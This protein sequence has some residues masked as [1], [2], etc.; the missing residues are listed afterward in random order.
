MELSME[1]RLV[2]CVLRN[3]NQ[4]VA[5][6]SAISHLTDLDVPE[7]KVLLQQLMAMGL[8]SR[9]FIQGVARYCAVP[10]SETPILS[11]PLDWLADY[12]SRPLKVEE[13][14]SEAVTYDMCGIVLLVAVLTGSRES[15]V[16]ER[17]T[18][19]PRNFV[20][21]VIALCDRVALWWSQ[22]LFDLQRTIQDD[23]DDF[24]E[25]DRAVECVKEHFWMSWVTPTLMAVL[26]SSREYMQCGGTRDAW[27]D[28]PDQDQ[29]GYAPRRIEWVN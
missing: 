11:N 20:G 26:H 29:L 9:C 28:V 2:L 25:I 13:G 22:D 4:I 3:A 10:L 17:F 19:L 16:I 24:E 14:D 23:C 27:I 7:V 8:C 12:C 1:E 21:M 18:G 6:A 15:S 5:S